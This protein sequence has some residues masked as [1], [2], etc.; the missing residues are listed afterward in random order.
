MITTNTIQARAGI[1]ATIVAICFAVA[2]CGSE[3]GTVP[4]RNSKHA[5]QHAT[6]D[7]VERWIEQRKSG[8]NQDEGR[9]PTNAVADDVERWIEL[10]K[11]G[12]FTR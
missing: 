1:G 8:V 5:I 9:R 2:A 7:D 12:Q 4:D 11:S 10:R 6:A 3:Q